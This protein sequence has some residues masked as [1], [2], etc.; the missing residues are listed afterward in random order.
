MLIAKDQVTV[1]LPVLNEEKAIGLVL[2]EVKREGFGKILVVD[3]YSTDDTAAVVEGMGVTFV[4][5]HGRGKGGALK[6][7]VENVHTPFMLVMDGDHSYSA[8][9]IGRFLDH[10]ENYDQI[11]G[12]RME[13]RK[14]IPRLH[15]FG[16]WVITEVFNLLMGTKLSDVC[17]GMYLLRTEKARGLEMESNGFDVEAEITAQMATG[18]KVTEVPITY[19]KRVGESKL[20]TWRTGLALL[21]S[22]VGL[23]RRFNPVLLFSSLAAASLIPA[24]LAVG[25]ALY[26]NF[27]HGRWEFNWLL[28]GSILFLLGAQGLTV[29]TISILLTRMEHRISQRIKETRST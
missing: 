16:N 10:A 21:C 8:G 19:K 24:T 5:Q 26:L 17:S 7:A 29:A 11:I 14:G 27:F 25:W 3:G 2:D 20:S 28:F 4:R 22:V 1:V 12:A 23:A 6:T 13:G 18:G 15:R 9:D